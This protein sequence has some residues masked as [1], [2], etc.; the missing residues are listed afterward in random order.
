[1]KKDYERRRRERIA[2]YFDEIREVLLS[3]NFP[4]SAVKTNAKVLREVLVLLHRLADG[5]A[6]PSSLGPTPLHTARTGS[7]P[8]AALDDDVCSASDHSPVLRLFFR[9][10]ELLP[11]CHG[12]RII[13]P[14]LVF[15]C[16][17]IFP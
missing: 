3:M 14:S 5:Q 11:R 16:N 1:M 4:P 7:Q 12:S 10:R 2:G 8:E 15:L 6:T 13:L 9:N 17:S